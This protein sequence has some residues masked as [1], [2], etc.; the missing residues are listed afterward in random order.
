MTI[1]GHRASVESRTLQSAVHKAAKVLLREGKIEEKPTWNGT[2]WRGVD[3]IE[4]EIT[5]SEVQVT[6]SSALFGDEEA[7]EEIAP[8]GKSI[9]LFPPEITVNKGE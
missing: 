8:S 2:E 4:P 6:D 3:V 5:T 9:V 1:Q 7:R